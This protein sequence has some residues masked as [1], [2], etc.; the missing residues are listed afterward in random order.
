MLFFLEREHFELFSFAT[1]SSRLRSILSKHISAHLASEE[2]DEAKEDDEQENEEDEEES[3]EEE[4]IAVA[5][6]DN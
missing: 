6:P 4:F 3:S 2:E 1:A 5:Q